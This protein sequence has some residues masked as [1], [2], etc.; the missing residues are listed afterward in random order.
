MCRRLAQDRSGNVAIIF[1]F[2]VVALFGAIGGS[3]D[4]ARWFSARNKMQTAMDSASLAGGRALQLTT[5]SDYTVGVTAATAYF[6]KMKPANI[7]G[8]TPTF[9]ITEGGTVLRGTVDFAMPSPFLSLLG[10]QSI[11]GRIVSETVIAAG[12]NAGTNFEVSLMLDTTGSMD[13]QKII[14]LRDAAKDLVDIVV[15][16]DQS[17]YTSKVA[18]APFSQRVNVGEYLDRVTD[19]QTTK[20]FSGNTLK[21]VTCVTERTGPEAFTD[22]KP[23]GNNTLTAVSGDTGSTAKNNQNN[24][25]NSGTCMTSGWGAT[26][27]P[28]IKPLSNDKVALKDHIG[29]LPAAGSTAGSLGTAWAWYL[30]SPNWDNVWSNDNRPAPYSDLTTLNSKGQPKLR[31][32][33]VLMTD[34]V[35]NTFGGVGADETSV[36]QKAVSLCTNMKAA[37]I[38]VY[39]VGFQLDGNET[40]INTLR[41]CASRGEAETAA[42]T[43]YFFNAASGDELRAS[44]RQIALALSTL[45]IRN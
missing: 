28:T 39:T 7:T 20:N 45:R 27:I 23:V 12:G 33:A 31:K 30:L 42:N 10:F 14:D 44:F 19:V 37:G 4:Y 15:W 34:G 35:Y 32:V 26:E 18:L 13:G 3:I 38:T 11:P 24:Y 8:G 43:S 16:D 2:S 36:S 17:Q 5:G 1:G 6:D 25:S 41:Q 21:G 40:A 29:A 9:A 22:A